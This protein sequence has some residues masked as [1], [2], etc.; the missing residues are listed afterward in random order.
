MTCDV[1]AFINGHYVGHI[2]CAKVEPGSRLRF[3]W[4]GNCWML[5]MVMP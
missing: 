2:P 4:R 5:W 3:N 1:P